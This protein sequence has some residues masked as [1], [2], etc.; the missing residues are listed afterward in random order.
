MSFNPFQLFKRGG[1]PF[2]YEDLVKK[3]NKL[4]QTIKLRESE[5]EGHLKILRAERDEWLGK[6]DDCKHA[7]DYIV[8]KF[9]EDIPSFTEQSPWKADYLNIGDQ[10]GAFLFNPGIT[11]KNGETFLLARRQRGYNTPLNQNDIVVYTLDESLNP[12]SRKP[13]KF[14]G[15][16]ENENWEDPRIVSVMDHYWLSVCNWIPSKSYA[17]QELIILDKSFEVV[18]V[19]HPVY[20]NNSG[21][22]GTNLGHEKNWLWFNHEGRPHLI[23]T[24]TPHRVVEFD[25]HMSVLQEH[26]TNAYNP[27]W[28][29][30]DP[31]GGTPPIKVN[32]EYWTFFH[33]S[34]PWVKGKRRYHMGAY[35]FSTTP[36]FRMTRMTSLPL[37]TGSRHDPWIPGLPLVIF[38]G[39]SLFNSKTEEWT[40]V[41]GVND[42]RSGYVKIPHSD[43]EKLCSPVRERDPDDKSKLE[44]IPPPAKYVNLP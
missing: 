27:L 5:H 37:L 43:L 44:R 22:V 13:L 39:G 9:D 25:N 36:P 11:R 32:N 2:S 30:G 33:S 14:R 42:C 3:V 41:F 31:R 12:T 18:S 16:F 15:D 29:Y 19:N 10:P 8:S 23:Y 26:V 17:H 4:E 24:T 21:D 28:W 7:A 35:A 1:N 40:V 20:G 38:P 34:V 6:Y